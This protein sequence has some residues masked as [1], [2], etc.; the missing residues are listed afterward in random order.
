MANSK[1]TSTLWKVLG[2]Y[3][4]GSWVVLQVIDVLAQNAGLPGWVF[5]LALIFLIIGLP[6]VGA[7]AY[8]HGIGQRADA[9]APD[10][11]GERGTPSSP[12]Q[13]FTWKNAIAGGLGAMALWGVLVTGWL[14]VWPGRGA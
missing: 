4:A 6:I 14:F 7:T 2:L 13:L 8:L 5:T 10:E 12:R 9:E 1:H 11:A 3:G